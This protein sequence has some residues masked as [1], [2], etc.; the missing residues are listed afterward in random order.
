MSKK[1]MPV[2]ISLLFALVA[3]NSWAWA[4]TCGARPTV[5]DAYES[6]NLVVAVRLGSVDKIRE[7]EREFDVGYI[8]SVTMIVEKVYKGDVKLGAELKF[9][10]GGGADCIWTYDEKWVGEKFLFYLR[11]PTIAPS[12]GEGMNS[13]SVFPREGGPLDVPMFHPITCG[14]SNGLNSAL[15]DLAYLDNLSKVKGKT[16]ISGRFGNWYGRGFNPAGIKVRVVGKN[17]TFIVQTNKNGFF[18]IYDLPPGDYLA[19]V[20]V[21]FGWKINDYMLRRTST[22]FD[23]WDPASQRKRSDQIPIRIAPARHVSLDLIFDIDTAIKGRVLSPTGKP[24]KDVCVMAV[25]TELAS[26]DHRGVSDCTDDKGEFVLEEMSPGD[27][28]VVANYD[29][30]MDASEPFGVVFYPGVT[31]RA[32]A[33]IVAV[34]PG[35][36]SADLVIKVPETLDL[37]VFKGRLLYSDGNPVADEWIK[38]VPDDTELYESMNVKTN[39]SGWFELRVPKGGKGNVSGSMHTYLGEFE[40]CPILE[41]LIKESGSSLLNAKSSV[42]KIDTSLPV[43][44]VEIS[45]PFPSCPKGKK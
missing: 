5:L 27:Y 2:S 4:C 24:M 32:K 44:L 45:F 20:E 15:D 40:N 22:G 36:Y 30:Q 34:K 28:Y 7:K 14:R 12:F 1:L 43:S 11:Q 31:D 13:A 25:S 3:F 16:R 35:R 41:R 26:G 39:G 33:A 19:Q 8:R 6:S 10:Q 29:G 38:F 17:K 42:V 21:P 9:A 23:E 37:V 18:E